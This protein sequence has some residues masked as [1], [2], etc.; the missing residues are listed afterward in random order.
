MN[1]LTTA[2]LAAAVLVA[3]ATAAMAAPGV[4]TGN[5]NVRSG[6]GTGYSVISSV[7]YG[8]Y[9]EIEYCSGNWC[10]VSKPGRDGWVSAGF[11]ALNDGWDDDYN[12]GHHGHHG[13]HNSG[14]Y[15]HSGW[16][17]SVGVNTC[18]SGQNASFCI[19]F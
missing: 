11:L 19:G 3:S 5:A 14:W 18:V 6:P 16:N 7:H 2:L 8:Q 13:H 17:N 4:V 12:H 9:V 10:H 1:K 15:N